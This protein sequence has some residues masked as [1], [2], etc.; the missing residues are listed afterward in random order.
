MSPES[1]GSLRGLKILVIVLG[2]L[3][4]AGVAVIIT[5]IVNRAQ[6]GSR[7]GEPVAAAVEPAAPAAFGER[8]LDLPAGAKIESMVAEGD[9]LILRLRLKDGAESLVVVDLATGRRLGILRV[10]TEK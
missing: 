8:S 1:P 2:V 6:S 9:R 4:L 10:E 7:G 3:I 5:T